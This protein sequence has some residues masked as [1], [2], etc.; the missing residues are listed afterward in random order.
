M[1]K[2]HYFIIYVIIYITLQFQAN[3]DTANAVQ[4]ELSD[5]WRGHTEWKDYSK[6]PLICGFLI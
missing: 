2:L 6:L 3:E 4:E 5:L 1:K